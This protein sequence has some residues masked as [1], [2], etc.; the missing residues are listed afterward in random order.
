[1]RI[2]QIPRRSRFTLIELLVVIAIIA[3]LASMLLPALQQAREKA[4][5]IWCTGNQKQLGLAMFMYLDD[6]RETYPCPDLTPRWNEIWLP[7]CAEA[8]KVFYCPS[9]TRTEK[10]WDT[11][12]RWFSYGY[13]LRGLAANNGPDPISG[14]TKRYNMS[15]VQIK[16]P[17]NTL[18]LV[19]S[20]RP[21]GTPVG[22]YYI[23]VPDAALS[24]N[25]L[26]Y[27]RHNNRTNALHVDGHVDSYVT[28]RLTV[29]DLTGKVPAINN[30]SL[31]SPIY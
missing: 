4:R 22:S 17:S 30:Y 5:A 25:Y 13:N 28:T 7:Y 27:E 18:V 15:L 10:D 14:V 21:S 31:W 6:N 8:R 24:S 3:I 11:D 26:P 29:P 19:D 9:D 20:H 23:A 16:K 12:A 2:P 1:M